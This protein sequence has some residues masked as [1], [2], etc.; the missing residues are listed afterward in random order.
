MQIEALLMLGLFIIVVVF[1]ILNS[2]SIS[3]L[4]S[5]LAAAGGSTGSASTWTGDSILGVTTQGKYVPRHGYYA[6]VASVAKTGTSVTVTLSSDAGQ[7]GA[8]LA[9]DVSS[10]RIKF[11]YRPEYRRPFAVTA[12]QG[13]ASFV[14]PSDLFPDVENFPGGSTTGVTPTA[15]DP[16]TFVGTPVSAST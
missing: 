3:D 9:A 11:L 12:A 14:A 10:G 1:L 13:S 4:N 15:Q 2:R 8:S 6:K 5:R 16:I 7:D